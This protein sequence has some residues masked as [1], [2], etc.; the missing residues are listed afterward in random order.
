MVIG[1]DLVSL[2]REPYCSPWRGYFLAMRQDSMRFL[3]PVLVGVPV[4]AAPC[5]AEKVC[6]SGRNAQVGQ[7]KN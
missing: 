5:D 4:C 7:S 6:F 3:V 1:K 2:I